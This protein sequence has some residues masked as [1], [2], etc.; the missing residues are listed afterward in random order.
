MSDGITDAWKK[1][2]PDKELDNEIKRLNYLSKEIGITI[3]NIKRLVE[4][5]ADKKLSE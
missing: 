5:K 3:E 1:A 4:E 2:D